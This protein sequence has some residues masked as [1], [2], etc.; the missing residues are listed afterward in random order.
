MRRS[1]AKADEFYKLGRGK[2]VRT[3]TMQNRNRQE[4]LDMIVE[5][6]PPAAA[7]RTARAAGSRR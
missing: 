2:L 1:I 4:L 5:R 6:L 7:G 3:S